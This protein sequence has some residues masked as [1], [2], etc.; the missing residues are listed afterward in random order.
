M[1][2]LI[3]WSLRIALLKVAVFAA[4]I[5]LAIASL[6]ANSAH[7]V[8]AQ[9]V[10]YWW[11]TD[12][13][14]TIYR[15]SKPN[16]PPTL[17][18]PQDFYIA[19]LGRGKQG[20]SPDQSAYLIQ[21]KA[22]LDRVSPAPTIFAYWTIRGPGD[23]RFACPNTQVIAPDNSE[24]TL[25]QFGAEQAAAFLSA[26]STYSSI[27]TFSGKTLFADIERRDLVPP[28]TGCDWWGHWRNNFMLNSPLQ[29]WRSQK[30]L[31]GFL[32][33]LPPDRRGVYSGQTLKNNQKSGLWPDIM[34]ANYQFPASLGNIVVWLAKS[35]GTPE[36]DPSTTVFQQQTVIQF[37]ESEGIFTSDNYTMG[38]FH[39]TLWQFFGDRGSITNQDPKKGFVS[40]R[41]FYPQG[42][43][44]TYYNDNP[45]A[46]YTLG[47]PINWATFTTQAASADVQTI[48]FNWGTN[49]PA[50]G[51]HRTFWSA[52][53]SGTLLVPS[54]GSYTFYLE[55]LDD[56][57]RLFVNN[58]SV[59]DSW[60]VQGP[61]NYSATVNLQ[62]GQFPIRIEY[63]QGPGAQGSLYAYW[64]SDSFAK[65]LIGPAVP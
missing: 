62:A 1:K 28:P 65:E 2:H 22:E 18:I 57:G 3:G 52:I 38:G 41:G 11:G 24:A 33:A 34:T 14:R 13:D 45:P 50:P 20:E 49:S 5:T 21:R 10:N 29:Y 25:K 61:H 6:G 30:V 63:A 40:A 51:V 42:I 19:Y 47:A 9:T 31:E 46:Q 60:L 64:S 55:Q 37:A 8:K 56:G 48:N 54:A 17:K 12:Y 7:N 4:A 36:F 39:P 43:H 27:L 26:Q 15:N 44:V 59:I 16:G 58:I 35:P 53:Y 32:E 23:S